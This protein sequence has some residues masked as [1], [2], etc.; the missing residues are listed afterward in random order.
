MS[1]AIPCPNCQQ[2]GNS[3][4]TIIIEPVL[5][6]QG[7][8]FC[9]SICQAS[10]ELAESSIPTVSKGLKAYGGYQQDTHSLK[11]QGNAPVHTTPPV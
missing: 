8:K 10:I 2:M 4:A 5:L 11:H 1:I 3:A 6:L 7:G 9:C